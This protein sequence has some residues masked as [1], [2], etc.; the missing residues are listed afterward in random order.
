MGKTLGQ[1]LMQTWANL[2]ESGHQHIPRLLAATPPFARSISPVYSQQRPRLLA[3]RVESRFRF[4]V[5][6]G[7]ESMNLREIE[8]SAVDNSRPARK[9]EARKGVD[10]QSD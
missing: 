9:K 5:L 3:A 10:D 8:L 1:T 7:P 2:G 4:N 6:R